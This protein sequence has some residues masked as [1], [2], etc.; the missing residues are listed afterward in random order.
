MNAPHPPDVVPPPVSAFDDLNGKTN[1]MVKYYPPG[2][3]VCG[4]PT[5]TV[6]FVVNPDEDF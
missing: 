5:K 3:F 1:F 4:E 6:P 2:T